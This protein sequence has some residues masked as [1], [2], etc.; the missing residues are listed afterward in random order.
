MMMPEVD[1]LGPESS[2]TE[3][4]ECVECGRKLNQFGGSTDRGPICAPCITRIFQIS[5]YRRPDPNDPSGFT[6]SYAGF[7]GLD[8][9]TGE[10]TGQ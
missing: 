8:P 1:G 10:E 2:S 9:E 7:C 5:P 3:P 4:V 6:D